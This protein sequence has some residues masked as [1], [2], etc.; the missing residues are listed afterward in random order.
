MGV[1]TFTLRSAFIIMLHEILSRQF[2]APLAILSLALLTTGFTPVYEEVELSQGAS[3]TGTIRLAGP[4]PPPRR[5]RVSMGA[6]PEYCKVIANKNG[7]VEISEVRTS[8]DGA[9]A[10]VVVF[11][12]E[13][14][15]GKP[16]T[17]TGP[18]LHIDRCQFRPFVN[19]G[20]YGQTLQIHMDD[21][22]LHPIRGWEM[23]TEGRIPFFEFLNLEK[24]A[25]E[26][27]KLSTKAS[28]IVKIECDQHRFMQSWILVP[29][30]PYFTVSDTEG[31]FLITDIPP[32]KQTLGAWHPI[33]GYQETTVTLTPNHRTEI[34]IT[35]REPIE[36]HP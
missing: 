12:Q 19:A 30:N 7:D 27:T 5:Y 13:I 3:I 34:L 20:R 36:R 18:T 32:G 14:E 8:G 4:P 6:Y 17:P 16:V 29:A 25:R 9:I 11:F 1:I 31:R 35:M 21:S 28:S 26:T 2:P 24:G 10:D 15:R 23:L 22:V 33:L